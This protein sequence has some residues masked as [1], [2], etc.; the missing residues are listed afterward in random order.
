VYERLLEPDGQHWLTPAVVTVNVSPIWPEIGVAIH[1]ALAASQLAVYEPKSAERTT[2]ENR[3]M[4]NAI[5]AFFIVFL[6]K[7]IFYLSD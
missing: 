5:E 2:D 4:P 6:I 3:E 7:I 1:G